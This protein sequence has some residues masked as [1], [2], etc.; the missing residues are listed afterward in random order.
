[1]KGQHGEWFACRALYGLTMHRR[2]ARGSRI[3]TAATGRASRAAIS[4]SCRAG[5]MLLS[6]LN[7]GSRNSAPLSLATHRRV[8]FTGREGKMA[9]EILLL[10]A[11]E[12]VTYKP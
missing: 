3:D 11:R 1:M 5:G 7:C 12:P 8:Y 10:P 4:R 9:Q 2:Q 6:V